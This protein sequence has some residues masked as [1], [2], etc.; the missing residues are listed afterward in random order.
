MCAQNHVC[1]VHTHAQL[2]SHVGIVFPFAACL[3]V[4]SHLFAPV[5]DILYTYV[6][7]TFCLWRG[8]LA[9]GPSVGPAIPVAI[10]GVAL[11]DVGSVS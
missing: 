9:W 10:H 4:K 7:T 5:D 6:L 11:T 2:L 1:F 3:V 8:L